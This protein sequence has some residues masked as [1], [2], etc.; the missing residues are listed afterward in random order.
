MTEVPFCTVI[1]SSDIPTDEIES[2]KSSIQL[3]SAKV[4]KTTSRIVGADDIALLIT[5][6]VGMGN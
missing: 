4:Q 6:A 1:I 2:L 5:I 3:T